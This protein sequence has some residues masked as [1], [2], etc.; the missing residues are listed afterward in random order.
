MAGRQRP[1]A[2]FIMGPTASGKTDLAIDLARRLPCELIS[3]DSAQVYRGMDIGTAKPSARVLAE[4]P[5]GL[6]DILDPAE[7]YSAALFREDA[8][9][10]MEQA[11]QRNRVPVLVGG[12]MLYYKTLLEGLATMPAA[13][14]GVRAALEQKAATQGL[15]MLHEQLKQVDPESAARIHVNDS[16]RLIRALEVW[17]VSGM[18]M[19]E[20]RLRQQR[21]D[22]S[23]CFPYAVAAFAIAP[24]Q[25]SV[26]HE[27]IEQRFQQMLEQGLLDEVRDLQLRGDLHIG[28]PSMRSVGYRQVWDHLLGHYDYE[29]MRAKGIAATR[30]LAK[31]QLTWLRSWPDLTW[32]DSLDNNKLNVTLK[33]LQQATILSQGLP[34]S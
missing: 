1:G 10:L 23:E 13:D 30:Q 29:Q 6:I 22:E 16:Q 19:T 5:H 34:G 9:R 32:L 17:Q 12:T 28:L 11:V 24:Q 31:R 2:V 26:L 33:S 14:A 18:T 8:L 27:R 4:F 25:R 20:H 3:V 21:G 7:S 15:S